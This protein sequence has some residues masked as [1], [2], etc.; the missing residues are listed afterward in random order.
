MCSLF[1]LPQE[2]HVIRQDDQRAYID[3]LQTVTEEDNLLVAAPRRRAY[4]N[5]NLPSDQKTASFSTD[6]RLEKMEERLTQVE[7]LLGKILESL[8]NTKSGLAPK[9]TQSTNDL[10]IASSFAWLDGYRFA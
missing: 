4:T 2:D 5:E 10:E 1:S 9:R 7:G 6:V 3:I 8:K